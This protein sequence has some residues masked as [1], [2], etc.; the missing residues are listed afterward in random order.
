[1]KENNS[2]SNNGK[3]SEVLPEKYVE[4]PLVKK[5]FVMMAAAAVAI[6]VGFLLMLGASSTET[7]FNPDIYSFRRIVLGPGIAFLGFLF[8]AFAI[9]YRPKEKKEESTEN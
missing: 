6:V 1:M 4:F 7:E 5:N 2:R 9:A 3:N 8:M